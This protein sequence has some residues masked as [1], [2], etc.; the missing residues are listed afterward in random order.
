VVVPLIFNK[1]ALDILAPLQKKFLEKCYPLLSFEETVPG[2]LQEQDEDFRL[3]PGVSTEDQDDVAHTAIPAAPVHASILKKTREITHRMRAR[4]PKGAQILF[5]PPTKARLANLIK[6]DAT[7]K[8]VVTMKK[9]FA[10]K[11]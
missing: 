10:E 2:V 6:P 4:E 5:K 9:S 3:D 8:R 11:T 1:K 7:V